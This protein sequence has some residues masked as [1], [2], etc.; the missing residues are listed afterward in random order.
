M[1]Y[2]VCGQILLQRKATLVT[3]CS[4]PWKRSSSKM[5]TTLKRNNFL[6]EEQLLTSKS[7]PTE[8]GG[9]YENFRVACPENVSIHVNI[10]IHVV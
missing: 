4:L 5:E 2:S 10:M 7:A 3:S 8:K 6:P 9:K 1:S